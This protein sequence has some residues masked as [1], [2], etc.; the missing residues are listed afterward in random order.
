MDFRALEVPKISEKIFLH[1]STGRL[2]SCDE[3]Y[4]LGAT[5]PLDGVKKFSVKQ[6]VR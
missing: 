1:L 6:M 3:D 5:P 4:G 2:A